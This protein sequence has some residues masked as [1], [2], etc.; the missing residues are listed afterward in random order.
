MQNDGH[1]L[2]H[3]VASAT[4]RGS[5]VANK[6]SLSTLWSLISITFPY[7]HLY[8]QSLQALQKFPAPMLNPF[9]LFFQRLIPPQYPF[10][11]C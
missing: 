3:H 9:G 11:D 8:P 10:Q 6:S 5:K 4:K 1:L 2:M 7:L